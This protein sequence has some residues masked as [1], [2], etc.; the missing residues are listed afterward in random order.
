MVSATA[1]KRVFFLSSIV[2]GIALI[3]AESSDDTCTADCATASDGTSLGRYP[4]WEAA[5]ASTEEFDHDNDKT[6]CRLA[7][8][9][10]EEWERGRYWEKEQ[11]VLVKNVTDGWG[12]PE[13]WT[14]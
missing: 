5:P 14:K 2:A 7:V 3:Y 8:I 10:V 1:H 4:T 9:S 12:A 6:V 13:H 11:P